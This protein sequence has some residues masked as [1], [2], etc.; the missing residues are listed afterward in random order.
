MIWKWILNEKPEFIFSSALKTPRKHVSLAT[1]QNLIVSIFVFISR[2]L[3][4][5]RKMI[6]FSLCKSKINLKRPFFSS[7]CAPVKESVKF[8]SFLN[9]SMD[10][11]CTHPR[12]CLH[13]HSIEMKGKGPSTH[14]F[15]SLVIPHLPTQSRVVTFYFHPRRLTWKWCQIEWHALWCVCARVWERLRIVCVRYVCC[16]CI[17]AC[18]S[19]HALIKDGQASAITPVAVPALWMPNTTEHAQSSQARRR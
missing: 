4:R 11:D 16:G 19:L 12:L 3:A 14:L 5:Q 9:W 17:W 18:V 13:S 2:K 6:L 15:L 7:A 1:A 10:S 8:Q